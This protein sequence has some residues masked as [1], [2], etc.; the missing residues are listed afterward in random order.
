MK[1][2]TLNLDW[3][4]G[5]VFSHCPAGDELLEPQVWLCLVTIVL[6]V[7]TWLIG[8]EVKRDNRRERNAEGSCKG[9]RK[10]RKKKQKEER[11]KGEREKT[12]TPCLPAETQTLV[13]SVL[14]HVTPVSAK[15]RSKHWDHISERNRQRLLTLWN[16]HFNRENQKIENELKK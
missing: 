14:I 15:H 16:L 12:R 3:P 8:R 10:D 2:Q 5:Q 11:K 6:S 1:M 13:C 9:K 7:H 4:E